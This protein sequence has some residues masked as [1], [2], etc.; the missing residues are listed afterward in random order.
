M[1]RAL[2]VLKVVVTVA[3]LGG[4]LASA[5]LPALGRLLGHASPVY[6]GAAVAALV[7]QTFVLAVRFRAI[8]TA[9]GRPLGARF[10][11]ELTFVG[12]LFNQALPSAVGGDA[13]R[14]WRLR[15]D[16]RSWQE[17]L[18][19][20][21]LDRA[22]GVV[23]LAMLAAA[24]V[25]VEPSAALASLRAPLLAVA[26]VGVVAIVLL[27]GA[28]RFRLLPRRMREVLAT[29]AVPAGMR[30]LL[31]TRLAA[32]AAA[33]SAVSHMLAALAAYWLAAALGVDVALGTFLTAALCMLLA[34]MIPL[35]YAGWGIR[36]AGAVW[37][38]A[39]LG[40]PAEQALAISVLFGAA[41]L[42]AALPGLT[43]WLA[44]QAAASVRPTS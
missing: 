43:F 39:Q 10:A 15:N 3:V 17:A 31:A 27:A 21:F 44:P 37:L 38:F 42:A 35:S 8:V 6:F 23:V 29:S 4:V 5:D 25:A 28:D 36:E 20:V 12:T 26:A 9:L 30:A 18:V 13:I 11:V 7:A 24:A 16:G 1:R 14:A 2:F 41:L 19:A 34:T 22:S 32:P 33:W 40:V